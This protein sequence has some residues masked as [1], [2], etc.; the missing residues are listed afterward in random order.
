M[1]PLTAEQARLVARVTRALGADPHYTPRVMTREFIDAQNALLD[2]LEAAQFDEEV[3][4]LVDEKP[5]A[6]QL[7][8]REF[9]RATG[10]DEEVRAGTTIVL[11]DEKAN[12]ADIEDVLEEIDAETMYWLH[13]EGRPVMWPVGGEDVV[14]RKGSDIDAAYLTWIITLPIHA[15]HERTHID[16]NTHRVT[17]N[18]GVQDEQKYHAWGLKMIPV[19]IEAHQTDDAN[20]SIEFVSLLKPNGYRVRNTGAAASGVDMLDPAKRYAVVAWCGIVHRYNV[21]EGDDHSFTPTDELKEIKLPVNRKYTWMLAGA[22]HV[23]KADVVGACEGHEDRMYGGGDGYADKVYIRFTLVESPDGNANDV[24]QNGVQAPRATPQEIKATL[25]DPETV[26]CVMAAIAANLHEGQ[27][28]LATG[29]QGER[30]LRTLAML[31]AEMV[32]KGGFKQQDLEMVETK[33]EIRLDVRDV[34][35]NMLWES[36]KKRR[37][38]GAKHKLVEIVVHDEHGWS[39]M[40]NRP[41][42]ES[43]EDP[44]PLDD[45]AEGE[46]K[47]LDEKLKARK[48]LDVEKVEAET[49]KRMLEIKLA[50]QKINEDTY[51]RA[52]AKVEA[53]LD[54]IERKRAANYITAA[55]YDVACLNT[56]LGFVRRNIP[57]GIRWWPQGRSVMTHEGVLYRFSRDQEALQDAVARHFGYTFYSGGTAGA[58]RMI[59]ALACED[60][61]QEVK[62][63]VSVFKKRIGALG[64]EFQC[65][66]QHNNIEA[67]PVEYNHIWSQSTCE[68]IAW[69]SDRP[70]RK[71]TTAD[72]R[73]SFLGCDTLNGRAESQ[74]YVREYGFPT[75]TCQLRVRVDGIP[76]KELLGFTGSLKLSHWEFAEGT[77]AW[78]LKQVSRHLAE[79]EGWITTVELRDLLDNGELLCAAASELVYSP[80]ANKLEFPPSRDT[81]V[82]LVGKCQVHDANVQY[83]GTRDEGEHKYLCGLLGERLR[84]WKDHDGI[85]LVEY[86]GEGDMPRYGHIRAYVIAYSNINVRM[87][88]RRA[89]KAQCNI[90]AIDTDSITFDGEMPEEV[91]TLMRKSPGWGEWRLKES[92]A[93]WSELRGGSF[94]CQGDMLPSEDAETL[95]R[96]PRDV[97]ELEGLNLD[98][99]PQ[100]LTRTV[101][102]SERHLVLRGI[103]GSGKTEMI[104]RVL[105]GQIPFVVIVPGHQQRKEMLKRFPGINADTYHHALGINCRN[106][107]KEKLY[108]KLCKLPPIVVWDEAY[109]VPSSL[110]RRVLDALE[111]LSKRVILL[112]DPG[113]L[114]PYDGDPRSTRQYIEDEWATR[115]VVFTHDM[116]A[117]EERLREIKRA[118]YMRPD[119]AQ[120]EVLRAEFEEQTF[121]DSLRDWDPEQDVWLGATH[122]LNTAV[123]TELLAWHRAH[124]PQKLAPIEFNPPTKG[125]K[126]YSFIDKKTKDYKKIPVPGTEGTIAAARRSMALT[127]L[128][129]LDRPLPVE[130][131]L[132]YVHTV[133]SFQGSTVDRPH[134]LYIVDDGLNEWAPN[135]LYVAV[136]RVRYCDQIVRVRP[137]LSYCGRVDSRY[138]GA[139]P[140]DAMIASRLTIHREFDI[141]HQK[142][143]TGTVLTV[144]GVKQLIDEARD[145][146]GVPRCRCG[147]ALI[148]GGW[149]HGERL[150]HAWSIDR[151]DNKVGHV[152]ENCVAGCYHCNIHHVPVI[153]EQA[154]S[155]SE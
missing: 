9:A 98:A 45:I 107:S 36:R 43:K 4:E 10:I 143:V 84:D 74:V 151:I 140:P 51:V 97:K 7:T 146:E 142:A 125:K 115:V 1:P 112:G 114:P 54:D 72:V 16:V 76:L 3:G 26:N 5:P 130:W 28:G 37:G 102:A 65:F 35:G 60:C 38:V 19:P 95:P 17:L 77:H 24:A 71:K 32:A 64:Y 85:Y 41:P 6:P 79:H 61:P 49:E 42:M 22:G 109:N 30:R 134:R 55:A 62:D 34:L 15:R 129:T 120:L 101:L 39:E 100:A 152:L 117:R 127:P 11:S 2:R 59:D 126:V 155:D 141:S 110:L 52:I 103:G 68:A 90:A 87:M 66:R 88:V 149:S 25:G 23:R 121:A 20:R 118:M 47:A 18:H 144:E 75:G 106:W 116:R 128:A 113:Q 96:L 82:K 50:E 48:I 63:S 147:N 133:H 104:V 14:A 58:S 148:L 119:K 123:T 136:S 69:N 99:I 124:L 138:Q 46:L 145:E 44:R 80:R 8:R 139:Y 135:I 86:E 81:G 137:P 108:H 94:A 67:S 13:E 53:T 33:L 153:V 40:P 70:A 131:Q 105:T 31:N 122:A 93:N 73:A 89:L 91:K 57:A 111:S 29:K 150:D 21:D 83:V 12:P 92:R 78:F 56:M 27:R 132:A 154:L